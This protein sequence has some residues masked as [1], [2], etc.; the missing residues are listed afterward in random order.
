M[1]NVW[2]FST[3]NSHKNKSELATNEIKNFLE[4]VARIGTKF[5]GL[6]GGEPTLRGDLVEIIRKA[7]K[8]GLDVTLITNGTLIK[9]D[10]AEKLVKSGLDTIIFSLDSPNPNPH[11]IIRGVKGSWEKAIQGI[12]SVNHMRIECKLEKPKICVNYVV[13]RLNYGLI[14]ETISLRDSLGFDEILFLPVIPKTARARDLLLTHADLEKLWSLIP[15]IKAR[16]EKSKLQINSL[17]TL[18]YICR[19]RENTTQGK[20]AVPVRSQIMCLQP[21]QMA[22][23]DPFGNV[24]PCCYACTFQNMPDGHINNLLVGDQF[25]MGNIKEKAF[26][27]IWNGDKFVWFR[28][29]SKQPLAFGICKFCNYSFSRDMFLTGLFSKPSLLLKYVNEL[30]RTFYDPTQASYFY[31]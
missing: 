23:I 11:D 6:S 18:A 14:A 20:Y 27:E 25:N 2:K 16:M 12:K 17:A 8:E 4:E 1:C 31:S 21:W 5:I 28:N 9:Q 10:L 3:E 29:K 15:S 7:K 13:T 22:T 26:E 30:F 19:H 24:Y